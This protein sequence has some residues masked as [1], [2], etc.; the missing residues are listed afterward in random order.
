MSAP[1]KLCTLPSATSSEI[2]QTCSVCAEVEPKFWSIAPCNHKI[3][4]ICSLRL[5]ALYGSRACPICKSQS[6]FVFIGAGR[7]KGAETVFSN[8]QKYPINETLLIAY[9]NE[10]VRSSCEALLLLQ[11]PFNHSNKPSNATKSG[12]T[13][14]F[15]TKN[16]LKRHVQ[17][18][19]DLQMCEI[20]LEHKKCFTVELPLY[21]RSSL[22][23]HQRDANHP[24]CQVCNEIFYSEDELAEHCRDAHELCHIC[25]RT[26]RP[27]RHFLNYAKLEEHF[28]REHFLCPE[29]LCRELKFVVF[30]NELEYKAHQAEVHLAHQK[31][32]R[33]QQ[34]QLQ[35]LNISF[36]T[37]SSSNNSGGGSSEST[38][39]VSGNSGNTHSHSNNSTSSNANPKLTLTND[40]R[41]QIATNLIY[42][43]VTDDLANRLQSLSL[44]QNRND[45]FIESVLRGSLHFNQK[46][47]Q[48]VFEIAREYQKGKTSGMEF[49]LKIEKLIQSNSADSNIVVLKVVS[50]LSELQLDEMKR[51]KL[52]VAISEY[53]EKCTSF[54]ELS[55]PRPSSTKNKMASVS[56]WGKAPVT[57]DEK[58]ID[59]FGFARKQQTRVS[60]S[61]PPG[62]TK[63]SITGGVGGG[64]KVLQIVKPAAASPATKPTT[65]DP[66]RNPAM[67]LSQL[68]GGPGPKKKKTPSGTVKM[69]TFSSAALGSISTTPVNNNNNNNATTKL[70]EGE[71]PRLG[72][73]TTNTNNPSTTSSSSSTNTN[74]NAFSTSNNSSNSAFFAPSDRDQLDSFTLGPDEVELEQQKLQF[75]T[76][77]P[78]QS[79]KKATK[80]L[81]FKYGQK[82]DV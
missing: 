35:R 22:Q 43:E 76:E 2:S 26:G 60:V 65:N 36:G 32:Q 5:R 80:K 75:Q 47:I 71:F 78:S 39:T 61:Q 11:C 73:E 13:K 77:Q 25:Q 62:F 58:E 45:E 49:I 10:A 15:K 64:V 21:N 38:S 33:S 12:C 63:P 59:P 41:N 70:D 29:P 1:S 31:L 50:G 52:N 56:P 55:K 48:E 18:A 24:R 42:G 30:E 51:Q 27:N 40:Q 17:N 14:H 46:Q 54:P 9:E 79:K 16:E 82:W 3:C 19:H 68:A 81:V 74:T 44:Y 34:R 69:T 53:K 7:S 6:E 67:L 66:S 20:C 57:E 4:W 8:P 37:G 23:K 72:L 28:G